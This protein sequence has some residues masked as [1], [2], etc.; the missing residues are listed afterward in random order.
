MLGLG[1]AC[2]LALTRGAGA[3]DADTIERHLRATT[4]EDFARIETDRLES[5][6]AEQ[7]YYARVKET[8]RRSL[9]AATSF[10]SPLLADSFSGVEGFH[11][12]VAS[13]DPLP[14]AV[15]IWTRYTPAHA[16]AVVRLEYRMAVV[17]PDEEDMDSLL[18]PESSPGLRCG[19]ITVT[20]A[21]DW[22]AKLDVTGLESGSKYVYAFVVS[23]TSSASPVGTTRTAPAKNSVVDV[24]RY[25]VFSCTDFMYGYFHAYDVASTIENLDLWIHLGDYVYEYGNWTAPG[26]PQAR[27]DQWSPPWEM[28]D[29]QDYRLR[30]SLYHTDEGLQNMRRRAPLIAAWD[31]HEMT[32]N[33]YASD[34]AGANNH[35]PNCDVSSEGTDAEK[36]SAS[37]DRDE[38]E[39][40]DRVNF[41]ATAYMEWMPIRKA[42]G[43]MGLIDF[44]IT[45]VIEWGNLATFVALDTRNTARSKEPTL[46]SVFGKFPAVSTT[47][48]DVNAY[49]TDPTIAA[50]I[51]AVSADVNASMWDPA[52]EQLG[53]GLTEVLRSAF[54]ESKAAG[55]P[56]QVF[57]AQVLMGPQTVP[58]PNTISALAPPL[59]RAQVQAFMD[60]FLP[61][62]SAGFFRS[63]VAMEISK[64]PWNRDGFDGFAVERAKLLKIFE[65]EASNA[66]VLGG[67]LHDNWAWTL[68][69][70]GGIE[71]DANPV[72]VNLGVGGVT[73]TGWGNFLGP[74]LTA[75][76]GGDVSAAYDLAEAGFV[77]ANAGLVYANIKDRGFLFVEATATHHVAEY[78]FAN[79]AADSQ[80]PNQNTYI[81]TDYADVDKVGLTV[82]KYCD[83]SLVTTA[84]VQGSL[85]K[86]AA[87][88]VTYD[89]RRPAEWDI[90]VPAK[91]AGAARRQKLLFG[92]HTVN[93]CDI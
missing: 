25:A 44:S 49:L 55:K 82:P 31:D 57:C 20:A 42:P 88:V 3:F 7:A 61:T 63:L 67:D 24:L 2:A 58:N 64:T 38:G 51:K 37:C 78:I 33:P 22:V 36:R 81:A 18:D 87:C 23:G 47:N 32:D 10:S 13:G 59:L 39:W 45:Q 50:Q 73:R 83:V 30:Y 77:A 92:S 12:G 56:W 34:G 85:R 79:D 86:Q 1:V 69:E 35:Q 27:T 93:Q 90:P 4:P 14:D 8:Q 43:A 76:L 74:V 21:D 71:D 80:F 89:A 52:F 48:T 16:D 65:L 29:L 17:S 91:A 68:F 15:V 75:A 5:R 62:A 84:G 40:K 6:A 72:A 11:H 70:R 26:G 46:A 9:G 66:I 60:A 41:A 54:S 53:A 19:I 28:T